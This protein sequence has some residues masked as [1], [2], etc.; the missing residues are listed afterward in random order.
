MDILTD[1]EIVE[2]ITTPTEC[3]FWE[4]I[5]QGHKDVAKA[6]LAKAEEHYHPSIEAQK[7]TVEIARKDERERMARGIKTAP[8]ARVDVDGRPEVGRFYDGY[9]ACKSDILEALKG[10]KGISKIYKRWR[11]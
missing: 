8:Y 1:E 7:L 9:E 10:E 5:A 4:A 3:N 6:Q 2:A 11:G